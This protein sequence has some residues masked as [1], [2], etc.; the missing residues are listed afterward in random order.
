MTR[1]LLALTMSAA[2]IAVLTVAF[3][4]GSNHRCDSLRAEH[5]PAYKITRYCE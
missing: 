4:V 3:V 5:A 2:L 1:V